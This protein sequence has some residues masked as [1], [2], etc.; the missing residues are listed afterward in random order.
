[1]I[2][3]IPLPRPQPPAN[4]PDTF[5]VLSGIFLGSGLLALAACGLG[6][7]QSLPYG[8]PGEHP[9]YRVRHHIPYPSHLA[10]ELS[11]I[12][13]ER[14]VLQRPAFPLPP[15]VLLPSRDRCVL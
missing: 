13:K 1:M 4:S 12:A 6:G 5:L 8:L 9:Y 7:L 3:R 11:P 10:T 14:R 15:L 2:H